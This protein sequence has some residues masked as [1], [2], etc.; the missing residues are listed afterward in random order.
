MFDTGGYS[1]D[2]F[3]TGILEDEIPRMARRHVQGT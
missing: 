1:G 2:F 3:S